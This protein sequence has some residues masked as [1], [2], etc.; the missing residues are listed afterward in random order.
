MEERSGNR[1][2]FA[3]VAA[4]RLMWALGFN[5]V[6][7][8]GINLHC[9]DCPA[10]PNTGEGAARERRY[11]ALM[12]FALAR[13]VIV[14]SGDR[15][16]G[17]SW[18]ELYEAI[19]SLP[20]GEEKQRQLTHLGALTLLAVMLQHGDRKP[21]QQALYCDAEVSSTEAT[22]KPV[23]GKPND[24]VLTEPKD[25]ATCASPA[26]AVTDIGA[27]FGGAG[28]MSKGNTAKM[29][30]EKWTEK[31]VFKKTDSAECQ[32]ALT[33]STTAGEGGRGDPP[34]REEGRRFLVE[35][36]HRLTLGH[37]HA[38]FRVARVDHLT[39]GNDRKPGAAAEGIQAWVDA[40][41]EKVEQIKARQ[42]LP[43]GTK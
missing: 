35:Q 37:V 15:D 23:Q 33:V 29:N 10:D 22:I 16:Q 7:A 27:T 14:S 28:R 40:F 12:S 3:A 39:S 26:V 25:T 13:P 34:I 30:L 5:T 19:M 18:Q 9:R 36:L 1:E 21:E 11:V 24:A 43:I 41:Q 8:M 38:L 32:G 4:S 2:V 6:P 17:W 20:P 42:C 31:P